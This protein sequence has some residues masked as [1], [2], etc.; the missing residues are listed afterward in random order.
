MLALLFA[1]LGLALERWLFFAEA[2]HVSV[3]YYG[4]PI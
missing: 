4:H 3:L 2:T 1:A